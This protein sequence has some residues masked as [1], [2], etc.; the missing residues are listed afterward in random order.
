MKKQQM[1]SPEKYIA[2]NGRE[3]PYHSCLIN[4]NWEETGIASIVLSKKMPS[5][6]FIAGMYIVDLY[7]LGLKNTLYEFALDSAGYEELVN[8]VRSN[9]TL[10]ECKITTAHNIIYGSIDFAEDLGFKP[11]KDFRITEYILDP[12]LID[13]GID[14]LKFGK[15]GK[16]FYCAGPYDDVTGILRTLRKNVG[17]GNFD[18][19]TGEDELYY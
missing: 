4:D 3:L 17:E 9:Y 14:N 16:P 13:D 7:C 10:M 19:L 8:K 1:P 15:D 12:D 6:K 11:H 2:A 18:F 5:G